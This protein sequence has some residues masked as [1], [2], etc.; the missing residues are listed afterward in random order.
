MTPKAT[1]ATKT[2]SKDDLDRLIDEAARLAVYA[3]QTIADEDVKQRA[4]AAESAMLIAWNNR[5]RT[6]LPHYYAS[7]QLIARK[8]HYRQEVEALRK[9]AA[10]DSLLTDAV[11][12]LDDAARDVQMAVGGEFAA[13][14]RDEIDTLRKVIVEERERSDGS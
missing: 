12:L 6:D 3:A 14:I 8:D 11:M 4:K 9:K 5:R 10:R 1:V 2:D 7:Q 13:H